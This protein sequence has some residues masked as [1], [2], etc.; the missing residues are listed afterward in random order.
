M[1]IISALRL[2]LSLMAVT[3][4]FR[5]LRPHHSWPTHCPPDFP[6]SNAASTWIHILSN[7][8]SVGEWMGIDAGDG[9]SGYA[10]FG[11]IDKIEEGKWEMHIFWVGL[12]IMDL[13]ALTAIP[14]SP[15]FDY[16]V[17][18]LLFLATQNAAFHQH[19]PDLENER[20]YLILMP[21]HTIRYTSITTLDHSLFL[22]ISS[23]HS[24]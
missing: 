15:S 1:D 12:S 2:A 4:I 17:A 9:R 3:Q 13:L 23:F 20:T 21:K 8:C 19:Q 6:K 14:T 11:T 5:D 16:S 18:V 24:S 22:P 7:V 10:D